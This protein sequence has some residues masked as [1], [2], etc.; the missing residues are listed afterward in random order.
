MSQYFHVRWC[1]HIV[2]LVMKDDMGSLTPLI[3]KLRETVKYLKKSPSRIYKFLEVVANLSLK[4][5]P[6]LNLD[7]STT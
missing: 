6:G 1:A 3:D 7:V 5:G 2:N 4:V